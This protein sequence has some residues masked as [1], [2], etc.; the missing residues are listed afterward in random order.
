MYEVMEE[1]QVETVSLDGSSADY[2][3]LLPQGVLFAGKKNYE[4]NLCGAAMRSWVERAC[5]KK[6]AVAELET[7]EEMFDTIRPML[8]NGTYT[9]VLF[10]DTPLI[11]KKSV[12]EML[13]LAENQNANVLRFERAYVFKTEE[14]K[15][16][17]LFA[18][19]TQELAKNEFLRVN[20]I[21]M[22]EKA[23]KILQNRIIKFHMANGAYFA[24][25]SCTYVDCLATIEPGAVIEP[26]VKIEGNSLIGAN[27]KICSN[28]IISFSKI[29]ERA[30][31]KNGCNII[32]SYVA[33]S[34]IVGNNTCVMNKS[35]AGEETIVSAGCVLDNSSL[36][37]NCKVGVG[38]HLVNTK[39]ASNVNIG[40]GVKCLGSDVFDVKI[41][42]GASVGAGAVL[43]CGANIKQDAVVPEL[44]SVKGKE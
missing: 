43:G 14:L 38:A 18:S 9:V 8:K 11:T 44:A 24:S 2:I 12:G 32:G 10:A 26:F 34:A 4:I 22:L 17:N 31:I 16:Q 30:I 39:V 1:T 15:K 19:K 6:P 29:E 37:K 28:T 5:D 41:N 21:D 7:D 3:V 35:V 20:S 36:N 40:A 33:D 27:A 13:E 42:S 25:P 23:Q